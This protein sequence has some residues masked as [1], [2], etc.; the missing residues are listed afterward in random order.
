MNQNKLGILKK[1][2]YKTEKEQ[3]QKYFERNQLKFRLTGS[4]LSGIL[5]TKL[6]PCHRL[7]VSYTCRNSR[8][9]ANDVQA[10]KKKT[11]GDLKLENR[12]ICLAL[13]S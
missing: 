12:N 1:G 6:R 13:I 3:T 9:P 2:S 4:R 8:T 5:S 10:K 7:L 11:Q